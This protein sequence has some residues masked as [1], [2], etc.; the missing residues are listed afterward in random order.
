MSWAETVANVYDLAC[1]IIVKLPQAAETVANV[2]DQQLPPFAA[3]RRPK[4]SAPQRISA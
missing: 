2:Y 4:R 1:H 3:A